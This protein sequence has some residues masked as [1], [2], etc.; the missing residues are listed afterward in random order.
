[1]GVA[2]KTSSEAK[3]LF[4]LGLG[5]GFFGFGLGN[6]IWDMNL[7]FNIEVIVGAVI[8]FLSNPAERY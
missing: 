2:H 5:F 7:S 8:S 4:G 3:V 6:G 1:M